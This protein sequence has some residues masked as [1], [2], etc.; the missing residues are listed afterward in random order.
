MKW[1]AAAAAVASAATGNATRLDAGATPT[2][3]RR[4]GSTGEERRK[5]RRIWTAAENKRRKAEVLTDRPRS[6]SLAP[7]KHDLPGHGR[8]RRTGDLQGDWSSDRDHRPA[9]QRGG[10]EDA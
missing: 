4:K 1:N 2:R 8:G 6:L 5:R 9:G 3:E 10:R 7:L